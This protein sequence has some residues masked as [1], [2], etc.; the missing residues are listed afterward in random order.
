M[1]SKEFFLPL[2]LKLLDFQLHLVDPG[3]PMKKSKVSHTPLSNTLQLAGCTLSKDI[4]N[5]F[6][7]IWNTFL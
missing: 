7:I 2:H 6:K 5:I 3:D 4:E 1:F